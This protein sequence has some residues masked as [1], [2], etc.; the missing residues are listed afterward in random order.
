MCRK[1]SS[2]GMTCVGEATKGHFQQECK[3][4]NETCVRI[5]ELV[6]IPDSNDKNDEKSVGAKQWL[7]AKTPKV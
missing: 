5:E 6:E 2:L 7:I 1:N 4:C 3:G